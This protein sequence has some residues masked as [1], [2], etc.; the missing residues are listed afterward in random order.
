MTVKTATFTGHRP[1]KIYGYA[2]KEKYQNLVNELK[3][4][5]ENLY[6]IG[7]RNFITGGAQGFDQLVFWAA[8]AQKKIHPDI[9]NIVYIP[10][11]HQ[12]SKWS[13][14]GMFG[15]SEHALMLKLADEI[16]DVAKE[17]GID[18]STKNGAI[19]ALMTRN[20]AMCND[21]HIIIGF[22]AHD[23]EFMSEKIKG[24]TAS[25]L[26]YA[27]KNTNLEMYLLDPKTLQIEKLDRAAL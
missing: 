21:A 22:Y 10:M 6:Q 18:A 25:C 14:A 16:K 27:A 23:T 2:N 11:E 12:A 7:V 1:N 24:G 13:E 17:Y 8:H 15:Q 5:I 9:K 26:R 19:Q 3:K 4:Q 20:E